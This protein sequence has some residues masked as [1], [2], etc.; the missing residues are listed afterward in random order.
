M[1]CLGHLFF[2]G[3]GMYFL[4][5]RWAKNRLAAAVAGA[6][7]AF[8][9]F[10][11]YGLMWPHILAA[12]AWMPWVVLSMESAWRRGRSLILVAA[13]AGALQLL[14]GGAEAILQTWLLLGVLWLWQLFAGGIP[15]WKMAVRALATGFW[16]PVWPRHN[17]SLFSICSPIPNGAPA[18][19]AE[20][21]L[22]LPPCPLPVG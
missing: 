7:F 14:S 17:C 2:A 4:A 6:V 16:P 20:A 22:G 10:T 18:M 13:L 19:P 21:W 3:L 8:N 1:F 9:G 11:W 12:L 5:H 15:A